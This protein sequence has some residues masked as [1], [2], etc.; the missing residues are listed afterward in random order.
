MAPD[1]RSQRITASL[2][3]LIELLLLPRPNESESHLVSRHES[4]L[5]LARS[6]LESRGDPPTYSS[7]EVIEDGKRKI[8]RMHNNSQEYLRRYENLYG[9][10]AQVTVLQRKKEVLVFLKELAGSPVAGAAAAAVGESK[11]EKPS[12]PL[13]A[14]LHRLPKPQTG[15]PS[16]GLRAQWGNE[17]VQGTG[18]VK[19]EL[20]EGVSPSEKEMLK[21]LPFMLLG[22]NSNEFPFEGAG[23]RSRLGIPKT[24]PVPYVGLLHALAEPSLLYKSLEDFVK[25]PS[26]EGG[27]V[28]QSLRA[29]VDVELRGYLA[30]VGGLE[31]EIRRALA[32]DDI[33][34][35]GVTL[36]RCVVWTKE[37]TMGLRLMAMVVEETKGWSTTC[38]VKLLLIEEQT[39]KAVSSYRRY[40]ISPPL[41]AIPL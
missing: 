16:G 9:R 12:E 10:L 21:S 19:S 2:A 4:A 39:R 26:Q 23:E 41:T 40:I 24:L 17:R 11:A 35:A 5:D 33:R 3:S 34:K 18:L 25:R 37:A 31:G 14:G 22:V 15:D 8:Q 38:M 30:L 36:K 6:I 29:A 13:V 28:G 7:M 32:M 1:Q 27:L 20:V